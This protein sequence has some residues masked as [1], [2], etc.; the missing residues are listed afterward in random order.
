M[1]VGIYFSSIHYLRVP[2]HKVRF[3]FMIDIINLVDCSF[4]AGI[5]MEQFCIIS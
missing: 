2:I 1:R 5:Q 4:L 3:S